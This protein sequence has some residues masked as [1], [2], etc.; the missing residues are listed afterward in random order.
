MESSGNVSA[1]VGVPNPVELLDN[2]DDDLDRIELWTAAL[3]CFQRP[4]PEYPPD[5]VGS[6][7]QG[8]QCPN[9]LTRP[10]MGPQL[11]SAH[12]K[13]RITN[14]TGGQ[15]IMRRSLFPRREAFRLGKNEL[16]KGR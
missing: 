12:R 11:L 10:E 7:E 8:D 5:N 9:R 15:G 2:V 1:E 6:D 14:F 4:A 3:S 16:L 13:A